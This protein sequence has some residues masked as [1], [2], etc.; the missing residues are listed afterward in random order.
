[1]D[2]KVRKIP[3]AHKERFFYERHGFSI[4]DDYAWLKDNNW[5]EAI[6]NPSVLKQEIRDYLTEENCYAN[7]ILADIESLKAEL[8]E[9][10]KGRIK[11]DDFT[12]PLVDGNFLY[13]QRF[14][15]EGQHPHFCRRDSYASKEQIIINGDLEAE[16]YKFFKFGTVKH[17]PN[18][19]IMA[20]ATDIKG[21][22]IYSI[23]FRVI[24]T[25]KDLDDI[26]NGVNGN[27]QWSNDSNSIIYTALNKN[28]RPY[29]VK[30][31]ILK[32]N[33][34]D[35]LNVFV[36][37]DSGFF[38]GVEKTE[39]Q[40]YF[41]I[42]SHDHQT[43]EVHLLA[44]RDGLGPLLLVAPREPKC[45]YYITH[46][47]EYFLIRTNIDD[48]E[49]YK[50]VVTPEDFP[51]KDEWKDLVPFRP[52]VLIEELKVFKDFWIRVE[53]VDGLPQIIVTEFTS[54]ISHQIA[55]DELA[56]TL[57]IEE[58]HTFSSSICRFAYSSMTTP[59][60]VYDYNMS[61]RERVLKKEQEIP[62]GHNQNDYKVDRVLA[63][64]KDGELIPISLVYKKTTRIDG[65]APLLLYA[66][67]AYGVSVSAG[68]SISR[69]SLLD[70]GFVYA[71]AHVRGGMEKGFHWYKSGRQ[72]Y[73][74]NTFYDYIDAAD[75]LIKKRFS[76]KGLIVGHGGSAGGMLIG[77]CLNMNSELFGAVIAQVPFVDVLNTMC[78][79]D[80]P[81][82]PP[83]W[84]EWGNPI[85]Y[86]EIF[87]YIQDYSPY[88]QVS[89]KSYPAIFVTAGVSD[90]RVTYWESAKWV[91]K[92]R[93]FKTD[94][95][96]LVLLT[97]MDAGHGGSA[98]RFDRLEEISS[99]YAFAI[100]VIER[101]KKN[102]V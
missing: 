95:N 39:D 93:E 64:S 43:T 96:V 73:K 58:G 90:P 14:S 94:E 2:N 79:P 37:P 101:L 26:I 28:L 41:L 98:G 99:V 68:F 51:N 76:S 69:L 92:L 27:F 24:E 21:S 55:F 50:I 85:A 3:C 46:H 42:K 52:G 59:K 25:G 32:T 17:S 33:Q 23:R 81:L 60:Q 44:G 74:K 71:I 45:E 57:S 10:M 100:D 13:L 36:E 102:I 84:P 49:D 34:K 67:G 19:R 4:Q 53:R 97:N 65:T 31:H 87:Q 22:E 72:Q 29:A 62:S 38:L 86:K 77:A 47:E 9:E 89:R 30:R 66:Y 8:Y 48:A 5:Q 7:S 78:D 20:Y 91:A 40:K 70:R 56:Y 83:E 11:R 18:H 54:G 61:T 12:V 80:L 15:K 1:M 63:P 82:T 75:F 35:D 88:D 16:A 6:K